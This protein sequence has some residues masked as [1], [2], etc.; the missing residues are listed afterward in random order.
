MLSP[1]PVQAYSAIYL[2]S[3]N[4][5]ELDYE[6]HRFTSGNDFCP[7]LQPRSPSWVQFWQGYTEQRRQVWQMD[8]NS[9]MQI[10][11][12]HNVEMGALSV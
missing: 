6:A 8:K 11:N 7:S 5:N 10:Q 4:F 9:Y 2:R 12:H 1:F 3:Y